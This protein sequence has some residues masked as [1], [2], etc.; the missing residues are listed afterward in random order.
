MKEELVHSM[1]ISSHST[2]TAVAELQ[3]QTQLFLQWLVSLIMSADPSLFAWSKCSFLF[4]RYWSVP[5]NFWM[6]YSDSLPGL[7]LAGCFHGTFEFSLVPQVIIFS[8]LWSIFLVCLLGFLLNVLY[9]CFPMMDW[10]E[11]VKALQNAV[12]VLCQA[13]IEGSVWTVSLKFCVGF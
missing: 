5:D 3:V 8:Y 12:I 11:K 2:S 13:I 7:R 10:W 1:C 4:I 6:P 9:S